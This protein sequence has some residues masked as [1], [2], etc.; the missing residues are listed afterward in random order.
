MMNDE[1]KMKGALSAFVIQL[2]R[3]FEHPLSLAGHHKEFQ[4][5]CDFQG[6]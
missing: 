3:F 5:G 4:T 6:R 2:H 1:L